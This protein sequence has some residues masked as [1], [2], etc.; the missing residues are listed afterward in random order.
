LQVLI[1]LLPFA[2]R[3]FGHCAALGGFGTGTGE[4]I[5]RATLVVLVFVVSR[6]SRTLWVVANLARRSMRVA[7]LVFRFA[8]KSEDIRDTSGFCAM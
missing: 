1:V 5:G 4:M 8:L 6:F 3:A 7:R 2:G